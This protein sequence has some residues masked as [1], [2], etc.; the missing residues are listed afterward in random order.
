[1][2]KLCSPDDYAELKQILPSVLYT[3][4]LISQ[5]SKHYGSARRLTLM[6][7]SISNEVITQTHQNIQP[8]ELFGGEPD[9]SNEKIKS[10]IKM[11]DFFREC[12]KFCKNKSLESANQWSFDPSI[13]FARFDKF[14]DRVAKLSY[15]FDTLIEFN[16]IEKIEIGNSK[17]FSCLSRSDQI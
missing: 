1:V 13:A 12:F 16:K 8:G 14:Y 6:L 17:V 4:Y 5:E 7:A 15:L 10:A 11:L 2:E 3:V 9:E